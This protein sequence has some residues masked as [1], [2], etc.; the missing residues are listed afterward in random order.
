MQIADL[1][2]RFIKERIYLKNIT[3]KTEE[4]HWRGLTKFQ[5]LMPHI[6]TVEQ[7][8][9][10]MLTDYV[11]KLKDSGIA[12]PS[13]NTVVRSLNAFLKWL[14]QN[15][16]MGEG[17]KLK[18]AKL[19]EGKPLPK[20]LPP[21]LIERLIRHIPDRADYI[22]SRVHALLLDIGMRINEAITLRV[23]D[24]DLDN[25]AVRVRG[26]GKE[27]AEGYYIARDEVTPPALPQP[28]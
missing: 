20:T 28:S 22:E 10:R 19:P 1:Y 14:H 24:L 23:G 2:A 11:I 9:K 7:L 8:D 13:I 15:E 26:K 17:K 16:Y 6:L 25:F 3:A 12:V 27:G 21:H 4:W 18:V 5:R